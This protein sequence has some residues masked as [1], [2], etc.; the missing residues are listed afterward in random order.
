[1]SSFRGWLSV[2]QRHRRSSRAVRMALTTVRGICVPAGHRISQSDGS[3]PFAASS[4]REEVRI[5]DLYL[6][7]VFCCS[8]GDEAA[9]VS[10]IKVK[11][12]V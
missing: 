5:F 3:A 9:S 6:L 4:A 8:D 7:L 11:T 1:M 12:A 10:R 2:R